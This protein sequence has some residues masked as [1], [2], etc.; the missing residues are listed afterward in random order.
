MDDQTK[1]EIIVIAWSTL[2]AIPVVASV[3]FIVVSGI[4]AW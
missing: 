2:A 3:G 1:R 4:V